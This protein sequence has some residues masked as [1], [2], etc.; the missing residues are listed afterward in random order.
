MVNRGEYWND[1]VAE[2]QEVMALQ[3]TTWLKNGTYYTS[4]DA[5]ELPVIRNENR[6][7]SAND[8]NRDLNTTEKDLVSHMKSWINKGDYWSVSNN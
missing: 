6:T 2:N 3:M 1:E 8:G 4:E 5:E 7:N